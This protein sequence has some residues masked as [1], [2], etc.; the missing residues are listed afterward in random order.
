[1]RCPLHG[2]P[3]CA[4]RVRLGAAPS[5][6][7]DEEKAKAAAASEEA[8]A[9]QQTGLASGLARTSTARKELVANANGRAR[10][11]TRRPA[12]EVQQES[13]PNRLR[14]VGTT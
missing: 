3:A 1:M 6:T 10:Y 8:M 9:G 12:P 7:A 4:R 5:L 2:A 13:R 14:T 11:P